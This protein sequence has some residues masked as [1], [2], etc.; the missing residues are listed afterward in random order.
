MQDHASDTT[1]QSWKVVYGLL[2]SEPDPIPNPSK[3]PNPHK[4]YGYQK[5]PI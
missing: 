5:H 1:T 3:P 4:L 2:E